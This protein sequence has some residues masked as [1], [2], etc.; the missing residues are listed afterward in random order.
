MFIV[1]IT[2]YS[3]LIVSFPFEKMLFHQPLTMYY[4]G[5]V[6]AVT[7]NGVP[8]SQRYKTYC[9]DKLLLCLI[10]VF[11]FEEDAIPPALNII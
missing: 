10:S 3:D 4:K 11:L 6:V 7:K 2:F 5:I 9:I 1:I 8:L